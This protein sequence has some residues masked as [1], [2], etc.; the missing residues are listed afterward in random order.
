VHRTQ[1][2]CRPQTPRLAAAF[3]QVLRQTEDAGAALIR[4]LASDRLRRKPFG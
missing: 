4:G 1:H 2:D 3:T